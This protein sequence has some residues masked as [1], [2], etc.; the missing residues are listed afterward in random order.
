MSEPLLNE[1]AW[2]IEDFLITTVGI[3]LEAKIVVGCCLECQAVLKRRLNLDIPAVRC[4]A[5]V[6]R[7]RY[8]V[9]DDVVFEF[10][11]DFADVTNQATVDRKSPVG[12]CGPEMLNALED[13]RETFS[14]GFAF[15]HGQEG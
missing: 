9:K 12:K 14:N 4:I 3:E 2:A 7:L 6:I 1:S 15:G 13:E 11:D 10:S 5:V 8:F